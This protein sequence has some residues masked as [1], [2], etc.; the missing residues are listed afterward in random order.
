[1]QGISSAV[2]LEA[3]ATRRLAAAA[4]DHAQEPTTD[5]KEADQVTLIAKSETAIAIALR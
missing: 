3:G 1:L 2:R 5:T 4:P